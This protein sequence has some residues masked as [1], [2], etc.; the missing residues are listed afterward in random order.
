MTTFFAGNA[1]TIL[2]KKQVDADTPIT[3]FTTA[4]ALRVY[5]WTKGPIRT[6]GKRSESDARTQ[7]PGSNV[8]SIGPQITFGIY[9]RPSEL[10]FIAEAW[11][12]LNDDSSTVDPT[13]HIATPTQ[14]TP[15][16]SVLEVNPYG[17]VRYEGCRLT[18]GSVTAQ[19]SGQTELRLTGLVWLSKS[20]TAAVA[21]PDPMPEPVVE[22]PFIFAE[23]TVKY[24]G[25]SQGRTSTFTWNINRTAS[26]AQGDAGFTALAIVNGFLACDGSVTRYLAND[27]T[28]RAVDT[29]AT[30]GTVPTSEVFTEGLSVL[31]T[32]GAGADQRQFLIASQEVAYLTDDVALN[33]DSTPFAEVI[34]FEH[35]PQTDVADNISIVTVNDKATPAG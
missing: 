8:Q 7:A 25:A 4:L 29:G 21:T 14:D 23:A 11:L 30:D 22:V 28:I 12:G 31:F 32:R 18:A 15:Y 6:L 34:A 24:A 1:K 2:I 17:N 3:D 19:D 33:L 35:Q 5:E 26:R 20:I 16:Y 27:D 13:T 10:D 9:G